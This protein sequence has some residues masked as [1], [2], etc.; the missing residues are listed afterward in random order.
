LQ[1]LD[2]L[3]NSYIWKGRITKIKA[4]SLYN[5][6]SWCKS[7][8]CTKCLTKCLSAKSD[9]LLISKERRTWFQSLQDLRTIF[10]SFAVWD[11]LGLAHFRMFT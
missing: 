9:K 10:F 7:A 3:P 6:L 2:T 8:W 5:L 1:K 4:V 11:I